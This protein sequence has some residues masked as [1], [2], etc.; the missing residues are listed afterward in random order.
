[1]GMPT[2][3]ADFPLS[4]RPRAKASV[5][6]ASGQIRARPSITKDSNC[7]AGATP[8]HTSA[9]FLFPR[10]F[11]TTPS[12]ALPQRSLRFRTSQ[13]CAEPE[14]KDLTRAKLALDQVM[15][16][17]FREQKIHVETYGRFGYERLAAR[18]IVHGILREARRRVR[19]D[20]VILPHPEIL[21]IRRLWNRHS[22]R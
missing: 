1:V 22:A 11:L 21:S 18:E 14:A 3:I 17:L 4:P 12:R 13:I 8:S 6:S 9:G 15:Q 10:Q 16:H 5:L 7:C 19:L 2:T 20:R